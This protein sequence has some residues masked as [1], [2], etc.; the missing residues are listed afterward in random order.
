M[1]YVC[2]CVCTPMGVLRQLID[3]MPSCQPKLKSCSRIFRVPD[4]VAMCAAKTVQN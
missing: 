4:M 3:V 2:V 1:V